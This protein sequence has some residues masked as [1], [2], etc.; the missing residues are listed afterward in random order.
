MDHQY[1]LT[2]TD[3]TIEFIVERQRWD[4]RDKEW[5][6]HSTETH[7]DTGPA[8]I[9]SNGDKHYY[10][11]NRLSRI[12]GPAIENSDGTYECYQQGALHNPKGPAKFDGKNYEYWLCGT[13]FQDLTIVEQYLN[14]KLLK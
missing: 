2:F 1:K 9:F 6:Y 3:G 11:H 5:Y 14:D 13:Q 4:D 7:S 12:D 8:I 10:N